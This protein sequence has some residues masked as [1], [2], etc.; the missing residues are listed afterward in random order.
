M[1]TK[2]EIRAKRTSDDAKM[3]FL[4]ILEQDEIVQ[5][6]AFADA[7]GVDVA[8]VGDHITA[9]VRAKINGKG[10]GVSVQVR[11]LTVDALAGESAPQLVGV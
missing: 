3:V 2:G 7:P 9:T 10:T 5:A 11:S 4:S 8:Q 1:F 6:F